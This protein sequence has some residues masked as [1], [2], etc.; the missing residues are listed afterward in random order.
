MPDHIHMEICGLKENARLLLF[1]RD[2]K[3]K[4]ATHARK[5]ALERHAVDT[6]AGSLP[7]NRLWQPSYYEHIIRDGEDRHAI[8]AYIFQN[9]IRKGL[10]GNMYD[11]RWSGSWMFQ[12]RSISSPT[13][14]FKPPWRK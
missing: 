6:G 2:F 10:V 5:L 9:P 1:V 12:W 4:T 3:G 7:V 8:A 14:P 13:E 11:W